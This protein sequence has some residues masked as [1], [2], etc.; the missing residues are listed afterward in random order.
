MAVESFWTGWSPVDA[1][2]VVVVLLALAVGYR[3]GLITQ[4][5]SVAGLVIAF[6]TAYFLYGE[7]ASRLAAWIPLRTWTEGSSYEFLT[8]R[9]KLETYLY[10]VLAF[11]LLFLSVKLVLALIGSVLNLM[12]RA[13][14]LNAL[15]RWSGAL[16][17]GLESL[18]LIG[19]ALYL[20]TVLPSDPL[21]HWLAESRLAPI[22][23]DGVTRVMEQLVQLPILPFA[24]SP[25]SV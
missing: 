21:Q 15:N 10:N 16:L 11:A 24:P 8:T 17:A 25:P 7:L 5:I 12:A 22:F 1:G 9:F 3:R 2:I 20:L 13:P 23:M 19:I 14:G 6:L 4:L 18:V